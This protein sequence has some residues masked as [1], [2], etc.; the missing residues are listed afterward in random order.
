MAI[1]ADIVRFALPIKCLEAVAVAILLSNGLMDVERFPISFKSV[2]NGETY[3]HIVLGV[4]WNEAYGS[5]GISRR[6]DL[7]FKSLRF[8]TLEGLIEEF[9]QSYAR[10]M[11]RLTKVKI[12][13][14]VAHDAKSLE[15]FPWQH[16][17]V[18]LE[19]DAWREEV[20]ALEEVI[21][22]KRQS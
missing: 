12:G 14:P 13:L 17:V 16:L 15:S 22:K 10:N 4:K 5:L 18:S 3:R 6:V 11:H 9:Q 2:S 7:M 8:T 19:N 20:R 1:A 21:A